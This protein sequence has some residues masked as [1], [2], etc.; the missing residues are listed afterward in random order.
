MF[1][2]FKRLRWQSYH[3]DL[4]GN[5]G[6]NKEVSEHQPCLFLLVMDVQNALSYRNGSELAQETKT[7][8][9]MN[10]T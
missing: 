9:I 8:K 6:R 1:Q 4:L 10:I 7:K 5:H 3:F 2:T